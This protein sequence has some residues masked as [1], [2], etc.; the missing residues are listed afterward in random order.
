MHP[1]RCPG[2]SVTI[3]NMDTGSQRVVVTNESGV[4]RA[5][6]LQLGR[7]TVSAER[8]GFEVRTGRHHLV[9]GQTSVCP[10]R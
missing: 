2:V 10:S 3:T 6:L 5:P 1:A 7:Y 4:F 8:M 9:A